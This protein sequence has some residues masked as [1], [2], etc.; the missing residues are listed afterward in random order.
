[1]NT[2]YE[3]NNTNIKYVDNLHHA[4]AYYRHIG[5]IT[6]KTDQY[7]LFRCPDNKYVRLVLCPK[8]VT[9]INK[10]SPCKR[11]NQYFPDYALKYDDMYVQ[12]EVCKSCA[13]FR[14]C[15]LCHKT[16]S[17]H[18][19]ALNKDNYLACKMCNEHE[20]ARCDKC[21]RSFYQLE[22]NYIPGNLYYCDHCEEAHINAEY[23]N[24]M[25][26]DEYD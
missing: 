20:R 13:G 23:D 22:L 15:E 5:T 21:R 26:Y 17:L 6:E 3:N 10:E 24:G 4:T 9:H 25:D 11:C 1:M 7:T 16:T 8:D 19:L 14:R 18:K 2:T 12:E